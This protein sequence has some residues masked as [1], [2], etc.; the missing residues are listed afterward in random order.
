LKPAAT[1]RATATVR[2]SKRSAAS[3]Q[4]LKALA[5]AVAGA[6]VGT[7][8]GQGTGLSIPVE[9]PIFTPGIRAAATYSDNVLLAPSGKEDGDIVIEA[10]PYFTAESLAPRAKY[11]LLYQLRN[12][13]RVQ[14]GDT[15]LFR[16]ALNATGSFALVEDRFWVDLDGYMGTIN[17]S[18]S[19]PIAADPA[20]SFVNTTNI[21]RF[22]ISPWYRDR[23]GSF[24]T[25]Q[26]RYLA[27]H[28]AGGTNNFALAKLDQRASASVDGVNDGSSPWNWRWYGEFQQRE[29]ESNVTRNRRTSGV[30]LYYRL[31]PQLRVF[32]T[33]DYEQI[34]GLRNRDGDDFGYGPGAGF[35][36]TPNSRTSVSASASR[37]Y[38]GT[39]GNARAAYTTNRSTLGVQF[40]RSVFTSADASLLFFDPLSLTS[41]DLGTINPVMANLLAAGIVLPVGTTLTQSLVTDAAV[42]DRRITAFYGLYGARNS[43][44]FSLF[45]SNRES[46]TELATSTAV[47]GIRGTGTAGRIF[48]GELRERGGAVVYQHRLDAR[49]SIDVTL[50]Q[51]RNSSPSAGFDTRATTLRAG[52]TTRVTADTAFFGGVRHTRQTAS[53]TGAKYD[54]NAIYGGID[55]R[56]R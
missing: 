16:H 37:R 51:R 29:F 11:R 13:W 33:V 3:P 20:A 23:L 34:D 46:T 43:L 28:T 26:L 2:R 10:S 8:A 54:E 35:D 32:G 12:F 36:W 18:A 45:A 42:L 44:T 15:N 31:N 41:G 52:Y 40:S 25:Y 50:D 48:V 47:S 5:C 22:S 56:F 7:A 39:V 30:A 1:T 21:R 55:V 9:R 14:D 27:A 53:G 4:A 6:W 49:S 17:A 19:G 24:A 38:Y